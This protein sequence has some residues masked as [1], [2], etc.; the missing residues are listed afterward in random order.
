MFTEICS[1]ALIY[2]IFGLVHVFMAIFGQKFSLAIKEFLMT[3]LFT[4][5]LNYLCENDLGLI[6]WLFIFIPFILM[7]VVVILL[8]NSIDPKW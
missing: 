3:I 8:T 2:L 1:P 6:S 5:A 4:I 7:T